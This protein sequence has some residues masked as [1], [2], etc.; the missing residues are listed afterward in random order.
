MTHKLLVA[1]YPRNTLVVQSCDGETRESEESYSSDYPEIV[2]DNQ[3][4]KGMK[5]TQVCLTFNC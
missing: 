1:L 4:A 2:D 5:S 3:D